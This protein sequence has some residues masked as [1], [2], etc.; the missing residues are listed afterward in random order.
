MLVLNF[1][2]LFLHISLSPTMEPLYLLP[3]SMTIPDPQ[4]TDAAPPIIHSV[5]ITPELLLIPDEKSMDMDVTDLET[6]LAEY[7]EDERQ[8]VRDFFEQANAV[9]LDQQEY[10]G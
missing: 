7:P 8:A 4:A 1:H 3:L 9:Q 6:V 10:C 5:S 2:Q